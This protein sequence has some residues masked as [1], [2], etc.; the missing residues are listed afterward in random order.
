MADLTALTRQ[1]RRISRLAD[2]GLTRS[3]IIVHQDCR[4]ALQKIR[5]YLVD[6]VQADLLLGFLRRINPATQPINVAQVAQL[7]PLRYPGG[8]TWLIPEIKAWIRNL[9]KKPR[10]VVEPFAGGAIAGLSIA[11]ENLADEVILVERDPAVSALWELVVHGTDLEAEAL[12]QKVLE[13][14]MSTENVDAALSTYATSLPMKAFATIVKNRVNRGGILAPGASRMK[15]GEN[16]KG[17]KSRWYPETL[18]R[19]MRMIRSFRHR[20][21]ALSGDAFDL[22][23]MMRE[24]ADTAWFVDPPYT[25][26]GKSAGNRLYVFSEIDHDQLFLEMSRCAGPVMMT[27]DDAPEVKALAERYGFAIKHVPMKTTH[28]AVKNELLLLKLEHPAPQFLDVQDDVLNFRF[29]GRL[30]DWSRRVQR[31]D[32]IV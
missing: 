9:P 21:R 4:A 17:L 16:G 32:R 26:S 31:T 25:A 22:F 29:K 23:P 6:P 19:R 15:S 3:S 10:T 27:Y 14:D 2:D 13:F 12:F 28:H 1:K 30:A 18:V 20:L 5:P 11:A 8:K 7:S 24:E